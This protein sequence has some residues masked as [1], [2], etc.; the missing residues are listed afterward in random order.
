MTK[1]IIIVT[2]PSYKDPFIQNKQP[3]GYFLE[4][5]EGSLGATPSR[6][7]GHR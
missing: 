3:K 5:L 2:K 4:P 7:F 1:M 6:V